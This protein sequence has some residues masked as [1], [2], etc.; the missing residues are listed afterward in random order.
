LDAE[1]V[2][3]ACINCVQCD[4][5][6]RDEATFCWRCGLVR[7]V[8]HTPAAGLVAYEAC[9]IVFGKSVEAGKMVFQARVVDDSGTYPV[10]E[11]EPLQYESMS[12]LGGES[13]VLLDRLVANLVSQGWEALGTYGAFYWDQRLRRRLTAGALP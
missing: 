4:T 12:Y 5:G 10:L 8:V 11:S 13:R 7:R 1:E 3:V 6:L 2:R 9:A